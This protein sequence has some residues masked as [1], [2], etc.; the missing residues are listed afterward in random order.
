MAELVA[1]MLK[2]D[3]T[4][5]KAIHQQYYKL[6]SGFLKLDTNPVPIKEALGMAGLIVPTLRR[7]MVAM[8]DEG[9]EVLRGIME[10]LNL[11]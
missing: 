5:A 8:S 4:T 11:L 1:A 9:L 2:D 10:E 3:L 6:F 7:P